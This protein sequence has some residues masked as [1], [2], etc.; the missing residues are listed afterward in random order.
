MRVSSILASLPLLVA[1][2]SCGGGGDVAGDVTGFAVLPPSFTWTAR[3]CPDGVGDAVSIHTI[4]GGRPPFRVRTQSP[5]IQ[6]GL[7]DA[8]NEFVDPPSNMFNG[9]GDLVLNSKD[10][11]FALRSTLPCRASLSVVVLDYHSKTAS[12]GIS[13]VAPTTVP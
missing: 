8:N 10:P 1:V 2:A 11:K 13:V 7:V 9:E 12:V 5:D 6:P 3:F 4:N